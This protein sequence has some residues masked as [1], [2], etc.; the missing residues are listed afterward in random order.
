MDLIADELP[1]DGKIGMCPLVRPDQSGICIQE[2]NVNDDCEG[3]KLCCY[4]GC[5]FTCVDP[6]PVGKWWLYI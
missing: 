1:T 6:A 3:N 4:N 2:C 5:G